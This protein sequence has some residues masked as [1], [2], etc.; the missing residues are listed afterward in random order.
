MKKLGGF[1]KFIYFLNSLA[2]VLLLLSFI[3]PYVSPKSFPT[4]SILSL[5]VFPL[6]II[7]LVFV[8]Y[9]L[10]RLKKQFLLSGVMIVLSLLQF[11]SFYKFSADISETKTNNTLSVLSYNV[12]LFNAYSGGDHSESKLLFKNIVATYNPD[13]ICMQE[14]NDTH[15]P[16]MNDYPYVYEHFKMGALKDG[17]KKK[18]ALGHAIYSKYPLINKGAFDFK[19]TTNNT[20]YVD[21]VKEKDTVRLYNLHLKS[22]GIIPSIDAIQDGDKEKLKGRLTNAFIDQV[23]QVEAI[24]NHKNNSTHPVVM[25]GDFNNTAFS[26][27]YNELTEEMQ[28]AYAERGAGLGTTFDFDGYPLR[29]DYI[30]APEDFEVL[31]FKTINETFSDHHPIF[32]ELGWD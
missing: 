16:E 27:I 21:V 32:A 5:T 1:N 3:L 26:Y 4:L 11:N 6:I 29:I 7:N 22:I 19:R 25:A 28:D 17:T 12:H 13:V 24:L 14:Y 8:V 10:F 9:W 23:G 2:A 31:S 18:K 20:L 30:L 15:A